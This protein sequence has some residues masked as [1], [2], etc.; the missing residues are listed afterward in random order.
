MRM[1]EERERER[2]NNTRIVMEQ[3]TRIAKG[4]LNSLL[5]NFSIDFYFWGSD[6]QGFLLGRLSITWAGSIET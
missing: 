1:K 4:S 2:E 6:L 3:S 5:L